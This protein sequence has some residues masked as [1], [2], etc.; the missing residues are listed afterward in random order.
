MSTLLQVEDLTVDLVMADGL[1]QVISGTSLE[2][3]AGEAM[4]LVGESGSGKSMTAKAIA[5]LLP[6]GAEVRGQVTFDGTDVL[7]LS[8]AQLRRHR[9]KVAVVFQDPR[10][11]IN[12]VR[13][14]QDFMTESLRTLDDVPGAEARRRA[15]D[16]L[17]E[18]G[19]DDPA[20]RLRQYPHEL[21]GG[22]LQRVMIA[23][24][25][26]S[27]P[28]LLLADECTTA[29]DVT[30]QSEVMAILDA[31]RRERGL[32]MLFIT[33][34]LELAGAV[35]DRTSVM[36]A[37]QVVETRA[38]DRLHAEPLHP[39]SAALVQARP[40]ITSTAERLVAIP[41]R[42]V[43]AFEAPAGCRFA[44]RCPHAMDACRQHEQQMADLD[45]GQVRCERAPELIGSLLEPK[46][47]G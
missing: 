26:L 34:D 1:R 2:I 37:G 15:A 17:E 32:S 22:M 29:L 14:I 43:S 28:R 42:P 31:L 12:P 21:S 35:C 47:H 10:A 41:G 45:T 20:K 11:H 24:A 3:N 25:L 46:T 40:D 44:P 36:Y 19:I 8:G 6:H 16:G 18:V 33:H 38:A 13:R 39:Y 30:T 4:G 5:R 7:A 23:T 9:S 27:E